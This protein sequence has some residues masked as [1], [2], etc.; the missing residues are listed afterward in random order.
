MSSPASTIAFADV[1]LVRSTPPSVSA[2]LARLVRSHKGARLVSVGDLFDLSSEHPPRAPSLAVRAVLEAHADLGRALAEHVETGGELCLVAGNHDACVREPSFAR[3][4]A[5]AL[6]LGR[7]ARR[8]VSASPWFFRWGDVH[9]EHGHLYDPDN[10]PEHPLVEGHDGLGVHFVKEFIAPTGAHRYLTVNDETPLRLFV[11]AFRWYGPR[12]PYVVYR[13]FRTAFGALAGSGPFYPAGHERQ[14]GDER[15]RE[16]LEAHQVPSDLPA[17]LLELAAEPTRRS[18]AKTASRLYLDR[19]LATLGLAS[20]APL[21]LAGHRRASLAAFAASALAMGLSWAAGHNRFRGTV[22]E[23][24]RQS[25][26][27]V[28]EATGASMVL[29]GHT[30]EEAHEGRYVNTGSFSFSR[31]GQGRPYVELVSSNRAVRR[32]LGRENEP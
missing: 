2:D 28:A 22:K 13:Y 27:R 30:H 15:V 19:V 14:A 26:L 10:A 8:R 17:Q 32:Y 31:T 1:H 4:L 21:A 9:V 11:S 25:A 20:A 12:A 24:L 5:D 29:L 7:E 3:D 6:A 16:F 18:F 23:H